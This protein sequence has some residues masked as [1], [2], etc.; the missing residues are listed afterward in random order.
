MRVIGERH[1]V[2]T[3]ASAAA[4]APSGRVVHA[5]DMIH[6][7]SASMFSCKLVSTAADP[8][9]TRVR[10]ANAFPRAG[11]GRYL[12][13]GMRDVFLGVGCAC[14]SP[15]EEETLPKAQVTC[16]RLEGYTVG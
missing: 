5:L 1:A 14:Y 15:R 8:P 9:L 7:V 2:I 3:T 13:A 6:P 4:Q 12:C 11:I 10:N 16:R